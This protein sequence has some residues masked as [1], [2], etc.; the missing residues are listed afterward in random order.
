MIQTNYFLPLSM[1]TLSPSEFNNNLTTNQ[2]K[3]YHRLIIYFER[4]FTRLTGPPVYFLIHILRLT[5]QIINSLVQV[6]CK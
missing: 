3:L 4:Q 1:R 5:F 6:N 2:I